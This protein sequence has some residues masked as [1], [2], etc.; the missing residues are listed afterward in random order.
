MSRSLSSIRHACDEWLWMT[1]L[2]GM[3]PYQATGLLRFMAKSDGFRTVGAALNFVGR[4][5][6]LNIGFAP[7][8]LDGLGNL[9]TDVRKGLREVGKDLKWPADNVKKGKPPNMDWIARTVGETKYYEL[10]VFGI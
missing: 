5:S 9:Q 8:F 1:Y 6:M 4:D 3:E 10:Y 2:N 7:G